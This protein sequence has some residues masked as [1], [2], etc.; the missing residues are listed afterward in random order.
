MNG[1][2]GDLLSL[3]DEK[4]H[5]SLF[6]TPNLLSTSSSVSFI[7]LNAQISQENQDNTE[8]IGN[9]K[10]TNEL[11]LSTKQPDPVVTPLIPTN[12][13]THLFPDFITPTNP[14]ETSTTFL[15]DIDTYQSV[16]S[17]QPHTVDF[18]TMVEQGDTAIQPFS[19][20]YQ[21][22]V[23]PSHYT[24]DVSK[25]DGEEDTFLP[26]TPSEIKRYEDNTI[27][28]QLEIVSLPQSSVASP[29]KHLQDNSRDDNP[30][31][32]DGVKFDFQQETSFEYIN[33]F[34]AEVKK[35]METRNIQIPSVI[36]EEEGIV[37][38]PPC[39]TII[40]PQLPSN[41]EE[42]ITE[43]AR[44]KIDQ[45]WEDYLENKS[46]F[47]NKPQLIRR[48]DKIDSTADSTLTGY[49]T[50]LTS[51]LS[52]TTLFSS[53]TCHKSVR[54][55]LLVLKPRRKVAQRRNKEVTPHV[56][57]LGAQTRSAD[58]E[59]QTRSAVPETQTRS[60]DLETQTRSADLGTQT[61]SADLETQT[62]SAVPETQTRS[63]DL[64]VQ[65]RSADLETQ[66]RSADLG[67]QTRS[68]DLETQTRS[69][70]L[71]TQTR[72]ADLGVQTRSADLETQTRSADLGTQ[73][74]SADLETQTRSADLETQTRSADPETEQIPEELLLSVK[75][76]S[77][78]FLVT[79]D[80]QKPQDSVTH[81]TGK[82]L[83]TSMSLQE[84]CQSFNPDFIT[85]SCLRQIRIQQQRMSRR[86]IAQ[87]LL[88]VPTANKSVQTHL[89]TQGELIYSLCYIYINTVSYSP[90]IK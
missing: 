72:S 63:A 6:Q 14:F 73:T 82:N 65:T 88:L 31:R 67:T 81:T 16:A 33:R 15:T 71:E 90:G 35:F 40:T 26:L 86:E 41:M 9:N 79:N 78:A 87:Q 42:M 55:N 29:S 59:T 44:Q 70:D 51:S 25:L 69:A 50:R 8:R 17:V 49:N 48:H 37:S 1:M 11:I 57:D 13:T 34:V 60:A 85:N 61:R 4:K 5:S 89:H 52:D 10:Q 12:N 80:T 75:V 7:H 43:M 84:A 62:R 77:V 39:D 46:C 32:T 18:D 56:A 21:V 83:S 36:S 66:T 2:T 22:D 23:V 24:V 64:G 28:R 74:R 45:L 76:S 47:F 68:A 27:S 38:V 54:K 19:D 20:N 3:S 30:D 53:L 58:L